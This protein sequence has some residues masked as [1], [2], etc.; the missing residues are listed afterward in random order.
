M[1]ADILFNSCLL[2]NWIPNLALTANMIHTCKY[3]RILCHSISSTSPHMFQFN[4]NHLLSSWKSMNGSRQTKETWGWCG[5]VLYVLPDEKEQWAYSIYVGGCKENP[6]IISLSSLKI[7]LWGEVVLNCNW[8]A[9]VAVRDN[10]Y[11]WQGCLMEWQEGWC[12][13][14]HGQ[15]EDG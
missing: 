15:Q 10:R 9:G 8:G 7:G 5:S 6:L 4:Q 2:S 1:Y 14:G 12:T 3:I 13:T 11:R